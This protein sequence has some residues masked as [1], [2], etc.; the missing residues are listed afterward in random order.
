VLIRAPVGEFQG[1]SDPGRNASGCFR[2]DL[3]ASGALPLLADSIANAPIIFMASISNPNG[4]IVLVAED[5][6]AI[7]RVICVA[8]ARAGF[9]AIAA[10]N[11]AV[12]IEAFLA[13]PDAIDLVLTD[14]VMPM[15]DGITMAREIRQVRPDIPV[16]FM[17]AY[18]QKAL[19]VMNGAEFP[20]IRK[21]F[22][23]VDLIRTVTEI[24]NSPSR[25]RAGD[26]KYVSF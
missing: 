19:N 17:S 3:S 11:G 24:L 8:L 12:G 10:E 1:N 13:E 4:R 6:T 21:P 2:Y 23:V 22:L 20:L 7:V 26:E 5:E 25:A 18:P 16:L 9:R 14:V 15:M